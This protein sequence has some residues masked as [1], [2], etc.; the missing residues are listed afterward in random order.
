[1]TSGPAHLR[2][3]SR[4]P[5]LWHLA[6]PLHLLGPAVTSRGVRYST[7]IL[8]LSTKFP[9]WTSFIKNEWHSLSFSV[10]SCLTFFHSPFFFFIYFFLFSS[11]IFSPD[12]C[13]NMW[14]FL[15]SYLTSRRCHQKKVP[16]DISMVWQS[17]GDWSASKSSWRTLS[18][19]RRGKINKT[20]IKINLDL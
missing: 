16:R 2:G 9:W 1:M 18:G 13:F 10:F 12:I 15:H 20:K 19:Q 3:G 7:A 4:P 8:F 14:N 11:Y 17:V 6:L 5:D